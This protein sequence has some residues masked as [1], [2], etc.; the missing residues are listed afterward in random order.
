MI[1]KN[2]KRLTGEDRVSDPLEAIN[3]VAYSKREAPSN[4]LS[5]VTQTFVIGLRIQTMLPDYLSTF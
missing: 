3:G 5:K 2:W 1:L 4:Q